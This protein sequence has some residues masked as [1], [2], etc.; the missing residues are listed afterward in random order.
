VS[1]QEEGDV[2]QDMHTGRMTGDK[3]SDATVSQGK[4]TVAGHLQKL[5]R[6]EE[7]AQGP[8]ANEQGK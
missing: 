3:W 8:D 4:P 1:L 2:D 6:D 5:G 7:A